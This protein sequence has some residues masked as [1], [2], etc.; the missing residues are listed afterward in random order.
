MTN[1]EHEKQLWAS[2]IVSM[3]KQRWDL[4]EDALLLETQVEIEDKTIASKQEFLASAQSAELTLKQLYDT[5]LANNGMERSKA[6]AQEFY[7]MSMTVLGARASLI[8]SMVRREQLVL[9]AQRTHAGAESNI[10]TLEDFYII[11]LPAGYDGYDVIDW[12]S[13]IHQ[14]QA[15]LEEAEERLH[16]IDNDK[17]NILTYKSNMVIRLW[18]GMEVAMRTARRDEAIAMTNLY[19]SIVKALNSR[20]DFDDRQAVY[21]LMEDYAL[22][23]NYTRWAQ[24]RYEVEMKGRHHNA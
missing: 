7:S 1:K 17:W 14:A 8:A 24:N 11:K 4:H 6:E 13:A 5:A 23:I 19:E 18:T 12:A 3:C 9:Q 10:D 22:A 15:L 2:R 21:E 20:T 16:A